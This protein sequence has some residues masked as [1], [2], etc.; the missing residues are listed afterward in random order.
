MDLQELRIQPHQKFLYKTR[1]P[2]P[3]ALLV[4]FL[5]YAS[6]TPVDHELSHLDFTSYSI[7][8]G[9]TVQVVPRCIS[10]RPSLLDPIDRI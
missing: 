3:F 10:E 9:T 7:C 8:P 1:Q 4:A 2:R 6:A 5:G